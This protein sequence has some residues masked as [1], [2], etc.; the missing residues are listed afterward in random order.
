MTSN[1]MIN[2]FSAVALYF[3]FQNIV[4]TNANHIRSDPILEETYGNYDEE[5]K[6]RQVCKE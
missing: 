4:I 5:I 2:T 3:V 1:I 6:V